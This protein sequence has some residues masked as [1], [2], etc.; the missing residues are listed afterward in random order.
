M[1][2]VTE[3]AES[4]GLVA[5]EEIEKRVY[6]ATVKTF[7]SLVKATTEAIYKD[8]KPNTS[9]ES[10]GAVLA[11][12][13]LRSDSGCREWTC[14]QAKLEALAHYACLYAD[15]LVVPVSLTALLHDEQVARLAIA[16][17]FYKLSL[18]RPLFDAGIAVLAPDIHCLCV[19]CG[20]RFDEVCNQLDKQSFDTYLERLGRDLHVTYRPPTRQRSWY[21]ELTGHTDYIPHGE[22]RMQPIGE[23]ANAP[24]WAP[25][26][27]KRIG[28]RL[29]AEMTANKIRKHRIGGT[30]F[31]Q[32]ARDAVIQ[33]YSG[34]SYNASYVTDS[35][36][37]ARF[38]ERIYPR[39]STAAAIRELLD[40]L[41]HEVPLLTDIPLRRILRIRESDRDSFV[42]YRNALRQVISQQF[43]A[44]CTLT[45]DE[46]RELCSDVIMPQVRRLKTEATAKRRSAMR[47]AL[48]GA[49]AVSAA[50]GL[51]IISGMLRPELE[52]LFQI[53]GIALSSKLGDVLT[54]IEKYP[55]EVRS[56]DITEIDKPDRLTIAATMCTLKDNF[57][58]L[59][60]R[61]AHDHAPRE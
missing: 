2:Y 17:L 44:G 16:D 36:V 4:F 55:A 27:L 61:K 13:S 6:G 51:G 23:Y 45:S 50:I 26:R 35:P 60:R 29:G 3:V 53:G 41:Q 42:L 31:G 15:R 12:S 8:E 11:S 14:R 5:P 48:N 58:R 38:L 1:N 49:I 30:L 39:D 28:G 7:C 9:H 21:V 54:A 59:G 22:L 37:E 20:R 34:V 32:L 19:D 33:Q 56:H 24:Q 57:T 40:Q 52:R 10:G 47:S 43:R 25:K 46:A 18:L